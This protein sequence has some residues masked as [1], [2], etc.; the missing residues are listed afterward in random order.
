MAETDLQI[1]AAQILGHGIFEAVSETRDTGYT[2]T[3]VGAD[4]VLGVQFVEITNTIPG[5]LGV[6]FGFEYTINTTPRGGEMRIRSV[7]KFPEG[8]LTQPG[9]ATFAHAIEKSRIKIGEKILFGF[10]FD[11]PWEIIP[12]DWVFE[13]WHRDARI[14]RK[15]FTVLSPET[16]QKASPESDEG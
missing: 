16:S 6:N 7:I 5:V 14:I 8:G 4:D 13:I 3:R 1:Q 10:G 2:S 9:G 11:E 12:G 15:T